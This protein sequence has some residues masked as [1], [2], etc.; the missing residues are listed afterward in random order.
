MSLFFF[1]LNEVWARDKSRKE[2]SGK[3]VVRLWSS[4]GGT[5]VT[6]E[7]WGMLRGVSNAGQPILLRILPFQASS[8]SAAGSTAANKTNC[9]YAA[10]KTIRTPLGH[11]PK[12]SL[13]LLF[14]R[15]P[16]PSDESR[17]EN[18]LRKM[19]KGSPASQ[20]EKI[21]GPSF[22]AASLVTEESTEDPRR[23]TLCMKR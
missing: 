20:R 22:G 3:G 18:H 10:K 9:P 6:T 1:T 12:R 14:Q 21:F 16:A 8:N 23:G 2:R 19:E 7:S 4:R 5:S 13:F 15:Q 17:C 11:L